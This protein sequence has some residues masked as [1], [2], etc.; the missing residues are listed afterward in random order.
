[1]ALTTYAESGKANEL[2]EKY[3]LGVTSIIAAVDRAVG[4]KKKSFE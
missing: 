3:G 2:L 1:V 4:R